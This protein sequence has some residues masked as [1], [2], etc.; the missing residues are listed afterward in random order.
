VVTI[1]VSVLPN[2]A[3]LRFMSF[4]TFST[5]NIAHLALPSLKKLSVR[6]FSDARRATQPVQ[7]HLGSWLEKVS[8]LSLEPLV[9]FEL[10]VAH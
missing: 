10:C 8:K 4:R 1:S 5:F 9:L 2:R 6:E 7:G 3:R